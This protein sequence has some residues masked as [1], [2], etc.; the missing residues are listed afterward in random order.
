MSNNS[1]DASEFLCGVV[2]G[3]YSRPWTN[4]Q[5]HDLY[6][7]MKSFGLNTYLYAPKDDAKHRALWRDLYSN[8]E[9]LHLKNHIAKC[10]E[11][12][13]SFS[14]LYTIIEEQMMLIHFL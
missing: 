2:E 6:G 11:N 4:S 1:F 9:L 8:E 13:V 10:V 12:N 7:K 3:F 5:R 14:F